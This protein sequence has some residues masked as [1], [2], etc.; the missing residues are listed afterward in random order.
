LVTATVSN[1][2][3]SAGV[4][5]SALTGLGSL[6]GSS[7]ASITYNAPAS[8]VATSI[9]TFTATSITDPTKSA[10]FSVSLEPPPVIA[11]PTFPD[12]TLNAVYS[13]HAVT[14]NGGVGPY[15]WVGTTL[16][17]GMTLSSSTTSTI[18]LQ[19]TPTSAGASQTVSIK[20]TDAKGLTNTVNSTI[21]IVAPSCS[22]N[23]TISGNV[24]GPTISGVTIALSVGPTVKPN[25]TTDSSGNY[26]FTGLTG[27]T[28]K[29]TPSL[30][31]YTFSP[32]TPSVTTSTSTTTQNFTETSAVISYTISGTL[33]YAGSKTGRTYI[34]IFSSGCT[35]NCGSGFA[36][37]SLASAPSAGGT[38]YT[39]RGLLPGSY[40]VVAEV[41]TLNSGIPN[42]S[43]PVGNSSTVTIV[44][45]NFSGAN[46]TL[47]DPST[48]TPVA[49]S[50][51]SVVP[52][53]GFGLIQYNQNNGSALRD[54]NGREIATSYEIDY[55]TDPA[56][57]SPAPTVVTFAAHGTSDRNYIVRVAPGT[58]YFRMYALVGATKSAAASTGAVVIRP[59]GSGSTTIS[60]TVTFPG[61]ATG[62]L[63]VGVY[64]GTTI[65]GQAI[66]SPTSPAASYSFSGVP[67]G[68]YQAFAIIDQNNNGLIEAS[69]ITNVNTQGGPPP[70]TVSG[71]TMTN[72]ITLTSA[73][74]TVSVTTQHQQFNG[75]GDSYN[76]NSN[77]SWGTKRPVAMTLISGPNATVPWDMPVD[78]NS[79][80]SGIFSSTVPLVGDTYQ[81]Q[82]TYSD[83]SALSLTASVTAV[84]NSFVTG[85]TV[86]TTAPGSV[87]IP[88]FIWV[89]PVSPPSPYLLNVGLNSTSGSA[90]VS[91]Q[92]FGGNNSNGLPSGT[93][94][95]LF[96]ADGSATSNGA[97]ISSLPSTTNY[98]WFVQ[99]R[100]ANGN[101][102]QESTTYNI[103]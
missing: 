3:A 39:V 28:Y 63:Y 47:T 92:D 99:V 77:L 36:A 20:V 18:N 75:S 16:P 78:S 65:Y 80:A 85:M 100:D 51:M 42:A 81:I 22:T 45:S 10:S 82:G 52:G 46:V 79:G 62:P 11:T 66:T 103:P 30:A 29:V 17:A 86:Q 96:N 61:P 15:T 13:P 74:S 34:R 2:P 88:L 94:S 98:D 58:Y 64:D 37:T 27:G 12:G 7:T 54:N 4:T 59:A 49:I 6:S 41:D 9:A 84:L 93:T 8:I 44:S 50:G 5:W 43:N 67:A 95:V 48:P 68:N 24:S 40:V 31:G 56:F 19:G 90:F 76:L 32:A 69:D 25:T 33:T 38:A 35:G 72:N 102:A 83:G 73:V 89:D 1:D 97:S 70:I 26:S 87:N 14:V 101:S 53:N 71:I 55:G 23:C 21:N 57:T 91:W 60:G